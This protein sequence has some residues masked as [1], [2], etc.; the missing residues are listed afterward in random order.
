MRSSSSRLWVSSSERL[1]QIEAGVGDPLGELVA[2]PLEL[3]EPERPRLDR[4]GRHAGGDLEPREGLGDEPRELM[5][6]PADL[7]P[8]LDARGELVAAYRE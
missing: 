2:H 6:E 4:C 3:A 5:L 1:S 7:A 8:Q